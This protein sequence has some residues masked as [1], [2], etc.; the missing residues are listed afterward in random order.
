MKKVNSRTNCYFTHSLIA[1][2]VFILMQVFDKKASFNIEKIYSEEYIAN[3]K[4]EYRF[5]EEIIDSLPNHGLEMLEF[6]LIS[7]NFNDIEEYKRLVLSLKNEDFF[8]YFYG[9][10]IDIN[11]LRPALQD[12]KELNKLYSGFEFISTSVLALNSLFHN[13]YLFVNELF[14]CIEKLYTKEFIKYYEDITA[15]IYDEFEKIENSLLEIEPL[16]LSQKIMGK[17]FKN[18]G[19][20]KNFIFIPSYFIK[21][22]AVRFF[23]TDQILMYSINNNQPARNDIIKVLKIISDDKRFEI[24]ELLTG[25]NPLTGKD[26]AE[27]LD[28]SKATIS[29]HIEQLK[30][31]GLINE[32]RVKN[33][34]FYSIN[35]RAVETF[36]NCLSSILKKY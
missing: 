10:Y 12:D 35:S 31:A 14:S 15:E 6:L 23:G 20:Y 29:H 25:N 34:K 19:P 30:E 22:K 27:K 28:L 26:L 13:K 7:N 2:L 9:G 36:L 18:R 8:Y 1:E 16:E 21:R 32:E 11:L 17:V 24:L 5:L 4:E 3:I 33:S